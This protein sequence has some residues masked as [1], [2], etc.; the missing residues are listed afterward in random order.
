[1]V[2]L[3]ALG[4]FAAVV[5]PRFGPYLT[6]ALS[7]PGAAL[8][9]PPLLLPS[10]ATMI[11]PAGPPGLHL[12][13]A[14]GAM[15][16]FFLL[17]ILL[18]GSAIAAF[19]GPSRS[20]ALCLGGAILSLLAADGVTLLFGTAI[21]CGTVYPDWTRRR[22]LHALLV[23]LLLAGAVCLLTPPGFAPRFDAIRAAPVGVERASV[24]AMM[25]AAAITGLIC[26]RPR[27]GTAALA[28]GAVLPAG[29][30]IL[31]RLIDDLSG[32]TVQAWWGFIL[33]AAGGSI[34]VAFAWRAAAAPGIGDSVANLIRRQGG[35]MLIGVG[36]AL[37]ARAA[38][39]P[40]A[41]ALAMQAAL[42]LALGGS[43]AGTAAMFAAEA[44]SGAAGTARLSR[45]GGLIHT[46]PRTSG[47][48]SAGL[49]ALSAL[50]PGIG[51]ASVW[52]LFQALL[53]AP[54][55]GS[56]TEQLPLALTALAIAL[57]AAA[58]TSA[59]VRI[60]GIAVLGRPRSPS[61][62]G[63]REI[64]RAAGIV[65]P[66][67]AALPLIAGLIPGPAIRALADPAVRSLI[68]SSPGIRGGVTMLSTSAA[69][70]GYAALPV[71]ALLACATGCV[72]LLLRWRRREAKTAGIWF[73]G[74]KPPFGMPFGE[75][76]AQ[77]AGV[78]FLPELP[79]PPRLSLLRHG[80]AQSGPHVAAGTGIGGPDKPG[81][82]V[83]SRF[84]IR[85]IPAATVLWLVLAAFAILLMAV[86]LTGAGT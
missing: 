44:M 7:L 6:A 21:L 31:I 54:R 10:A 43:L 55:T 80:P 17:L 62:A 73:G 37:I 57:S 65:L 33:L 1:M 69:S 39:L 26:L 16:A 83:R 23:P 67:L 71:A 76:M 29:I 3:L 34:A 79:P 66:V 70:P 20:T 86:A 82:D 24:A 63:A 53:Y 11:L 61:G 49:L 4:A 64:A 36:L 25:T 22:G 13:L 9:L 41:Q 84:P 72:I 78:G 58:A 27:D 38:D 48:L 12:H 32:Q 15:P 59:S 75:P 5:P 35:L 19:G 46:M 74:L 45:L 85:S 56:L 68:G 60:I 30:A 28:A 81:H 47:A 2:A 42:L 18:S 8:C 40:Q 77:S 14:L 51:F 50:P 52:L